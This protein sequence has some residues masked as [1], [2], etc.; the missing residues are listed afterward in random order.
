MLL[1]SFNSGNNESSFVSK[2]C[3]G[4]RFFGVQGLQVGRQFDFIILEHLDDLVGFVGIGDKDFK[5][6]KGIK[7]LY[8][9][10]IFDQ[11]ETVNVAHLLVAGKL[12]ANRLKFVAF[13]VD[14]QN[15]L[16]L[17]IGKVKSAVVVDLAVSE[18]Q[19][20]LDVEVVDVNMGRMEKEQRKKDNHGLYLSV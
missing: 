8:D 12:V 6:V 13:G 19:R 10:V 2:L 11:S 5:D 3:I 1:Q 7:P 15:L 16:F 20:A 9:Q 18:M 4:L 17:W 14:A